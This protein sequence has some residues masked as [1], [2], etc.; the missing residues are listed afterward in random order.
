MSLARKAIIG[1]MWTSGSNYFSQ[2]V[3]FLS[4]AVLGRLLLEQDY[5]LFATA[6]SIIQ[7]IF[8]LSAFSFNLSITQCHEQKDKL[9]GTAFILYIIISIASLLL[10]AVAVA[11]YSFFR[12]LSILEISVIVSLAIANIFNL[13]GQLFDAIL[14]RNLEFKKVSVI[15]FIM[16]VANPSVAILLAFSG[17]GVWSMVA[18]QIIAGFIFMGGGYLY[19][20]W[21]IKFE[22]SRETITWY[23]HLGWRF[24]GSRALEVVYSEL[25]RLVIKSMNNYNQVGIYD[26]ANLAARYPA[27]VVT[28]AIISVAFP[29]YSKVKNEKNRLSDAYGL[30][31]YFLVRVMLPFGLIFFL[32]PDQFMVAVF[33]TRWLPS[34]EVLRILA[35]Y[36][37]LHPVVENVRVL[38]YSLGKPE[39]VAK[40]RFLQ[41]LVYIPLLWFFV[42][43]QGITGAAY[44]ILI[45]IVITYALFVLRMLKYVDFSFL[46]TVIYPFVFT[47]FT[48]G[49]WHVIPLPVIENKIIGM[50]VFSIIIFTIF[51]LWTVIF[52]HRELF[53]RIRY[54]RATLV[55]TTT[56][57]SNSHQ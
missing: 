2:G 23:L 13:F 18:G 29:V 17:A 41:I 35:L 48:I 55:E 37:V 15:S 38:F 54:L 49:C 51:L 24:L 5:G 4:Q 7:F 40:V 46:K 21:R 8:I 32:I 26:R 33:G 6:N 20:G 19:A 39:E 53:R 43:K 57:E 34:A 52:E 12:V 42:W 31:N 44:A 25:D 28:P 3:G 30:V 36:A 10:T 11:C 22:Y 14:Q 27:R 50:I 16:N 1:A 9:Y 45:S 56:S 47:A